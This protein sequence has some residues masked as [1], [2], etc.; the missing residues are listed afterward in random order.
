MLVPMQNQQTIQHMQEH[1]IHHTNDEMSKE[2]K[3]IKT[4]P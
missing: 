1:R 2:I 3:H 4:L